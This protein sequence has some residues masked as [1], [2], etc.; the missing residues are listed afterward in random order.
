MNNPAKKLSQSHDVAAKVTQILQGR[1][2]LASER[3][4]ERI[5]QACEQQVASLTTNPLA[6]WQAW[7]SSA[8]YGVDFAQRAILLWDTLR[9]RGNN[10]HRARAA[11]IAAGAALRL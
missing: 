11:G 1:T 5:E 10:F 4:K 7:A 8:Q 6:P 2:K 9:Q 3:F